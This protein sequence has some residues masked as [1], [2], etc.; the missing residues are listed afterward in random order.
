M[1]WRSIAAALLLIA[2]AQT[3]G[4]LETGAHVDADPSTSDVPER[5]GTPRRTMRPNE[6]TSGLTALIARAHAPITN[7]I[8]WA[9]SGPMPQA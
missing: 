1:M 4:G 6:H 8:F 7:T 3:A 2:A 5:Q 9:T